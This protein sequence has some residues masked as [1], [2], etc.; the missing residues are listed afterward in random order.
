[1]GKVI[2]VQTNAFET[3]DGY[4]EVAVGAFEF[5]DKKKPALGIRVGNKVTVYGS[6]RSTDC[7]DEF[8]TRL[9]EILGIKEV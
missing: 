7:A 8:M 5:P 3:K 1:M 4:D 9:G 2:C 6:F